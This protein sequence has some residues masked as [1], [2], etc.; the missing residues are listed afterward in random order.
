[1][2]PGN[3]E[4]V[5]D[6]AMIQTQLFILT[7]ICCF[8]QDTMSPNVTVIP[9]KGG[10]LR[11]CH[12]LH[13]EQSPQKMGTQSLAKLVPLL[14]GGS[15]VWQPRAEHI[16]FQVSNETRGEL[17]KGLYEGRASLGPYHPG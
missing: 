13:F 17:R 12:W 6:R 15:T 2:R 11:V 7:R 16:Q 9:R 8:P 5:S 10:D 4:T 14:S 3:T 1:M